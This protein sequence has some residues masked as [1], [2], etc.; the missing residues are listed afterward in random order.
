MKIVNRD[1]SIPYQYVLCADT[2][3]L[4]SLLYSIVQYNCKHIPGGIH[5]LT[6]NS[7]PTKDKATPS[8]LNNYSILKKTQTHTVSG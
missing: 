7:K 1:K 2:E 8:H 5:V 3:N 6:Q 4:H